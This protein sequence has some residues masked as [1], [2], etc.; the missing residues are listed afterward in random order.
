MDPELYT[1]R[2]T[3]VNYCAM[4]RNLI[5]SKGLEALNLITIQTMQRAWELLTA[6]TFD[7]KKF[8]LVTYLLIGWLWKSYNDMLL[9]AP[10]NTGNFTAEKLRDIE[11]AWKSRAK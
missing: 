9:V 8:E 5:T 6:E 2:T 10:E 3:A 4:L 1:D 7:R 11:L